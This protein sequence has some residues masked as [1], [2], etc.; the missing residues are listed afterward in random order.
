MYAG[1]GGE[2]GETGI[3]YDVGVLQYLY[4]GSKA[5]GAPKANATE[6]Y[7]GLG[8]GWFSGKYSHVVSDEAFAFD[9]ADGSYY[10]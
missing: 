5:S 4:P 8:Y 9:D 1:F 3:S 10:V 2:F 7:A 6:L